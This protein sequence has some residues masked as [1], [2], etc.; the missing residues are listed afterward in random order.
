[1]ATIQSIPKLALSD[2]S[3][4]DH[5]FNQPVFVSAS[6]IIFT[7]FT[8]IALSDKSNSDHNF[9]QPVFSNISAIAFVESIKD[10]KL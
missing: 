1:M 8:P 4:S 7:Q 6:A 5:S 3:N 9:N 10:L 2:K